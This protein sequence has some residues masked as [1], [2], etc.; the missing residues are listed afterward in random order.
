MLHIYHLIFVTEILEVWWERWDFHIERW[1]PTK[2]YLYFQG[3]SSLV[4]SINIGRYCT[5]DVLALVQSE[6][7][8]V[9]AYTPVWF[10]QQPTFLTNTPATPARISLPSGGASDP[11]IDLNQWLQL[12]Q[13]PWEVNCSPRFQTK[14][15]PHPACRGSGAAETIGTQNKSCN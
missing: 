15:G 11:N 8:C 13:G 1:R 10:L 6:G 3:S 9:W 14:T 5:Y 4:I 12:K 7:F 2:H